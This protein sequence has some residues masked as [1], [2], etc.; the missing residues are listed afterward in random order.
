MHQPD[1][2]LPNNWLFQMGL[3]QLGTI[4]WQLSPAELIEASI[5]QGEGVLSDQGALVCYTGKFT[6]RSPED[7]FIVRDA[8]TEHVVWWGAVNNPFDPDKF[9][10]LYQ[11]MT[12]FLEG[13]EVYVRD[14][15]ARMLPDHRLKIRCINTQPWHN[16]F[17]NNLFLQVNYQ[18]TFD[19]IPDFTV[20]HIPD[21]QAT[22]A[23]DGTKRANFT[24]I[25]FTR[26]IILIGGTGYAGEIKKSIFTVLN[27]L[28]PQKHQVLPMHCAAT[29]G[30][31]GDTAIYFGL[32]GTGKTT[33]SADP[34]RSLIGDDEHGWHESGIFNFEG[35]CYAKAVNLDIDQEPQIFKAIKFGAILENVCFEPGTRT[36]DY[37]NTSITENIRSA[38][39][40]DFIPG[41]QIPS[42]GGVPKHIFF[43]SCD[44]HGVLPPIARLTESQAMYYFIAGYT[45]K[46]AGT[47]AGITAPKSV[48]SACFG[49]PFLPLHPTQYATMLGHRLRKYGSTVGLVNTGWV[50]GGYGVGSRISLPYTRAMIGAAL[51]G[52]LDQVEYIKHPIFDLSMPQSCPHVPS[53]ILDPS[54]GWADSDAYTAASYTL[55]KAFEQNLAPYQGFF[56]Q[57]LAD[58]VQA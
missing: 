6:G 35:G 20:L 28:L 3:N 24:I 44:A 8:E 13:K 32:S 21:Y 34:N 9:D 38:Y 14:A 41:A 52:D 11:K 30:K 49:L 22:P 2:T 57:V 58:P 18:E 37:T 10:A 36:V 42:V 45:A 15:Y 23:E 19:L 26:R 7:K 47:E 5:R 53:E 33:L 56:K 31:S 39:P 51:N 46:I 48:F 43:L 40:I 25:N 50:G 54:T 55:L 1:T 29:K 27:Y 12:K 16:L 4:H 17:F